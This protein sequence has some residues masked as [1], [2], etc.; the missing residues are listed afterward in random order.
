MLVMTLSN[1]MHRFYLIT[2]KYSRLSHKKS[3]RIQT[4]GKCWSEFITEIWRT[5]CITA[6]NNWFF[7]FQTTDICTRLSFYQQC[8]KLLALRFVALCWCHALMVCSSFFPLLLLFVQFSFQ[9]CNFEISLCRKALT[10]FSCWWFL[11]REWTSF[12]FLCCW[13]VSM[14]KGRIYLRVIN[15]DV[16]KEKPSLDDYGVMKMT[17]HQLLMWK[18]C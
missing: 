14:T 6:R 1:K 15:L 2:N 9:G 5:K 10:R 4:M 16:N 11:S 8:Y 18:S 17:L 13:L 3:G 7:W 12:A